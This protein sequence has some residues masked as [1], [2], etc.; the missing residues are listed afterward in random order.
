M[1]SRRLWILLVLL[2]FLLALER[3][4]E[5]YVIM[6]IGDP[7]QLEQALDTLHTDL[8][9]LIK[10]VE[11]RA[12]ESLDDT[13]LVGF[14][15]GFE[16]LRN[17]LPLIDHQMIKEGTTRNLAQSLC[18][19]TMTR[20]LTSTLRI[21]AGEASGRVRA[22]ENLAERMSMTGEPLE[23]L[24]PHLAE[25]QRSGEISSENADL[26][27]RAL[28]PVTRRGFDPEA[29]DAGEQLLARF[30][31][32]F[33]PKDL[34]RLAKQVVDR[35]DPDGTLPDEELQTDRRFFRMRPTKD[36]SYAGE[37]RLTSDCGA[38]LQSLLHPL[39]KPRVNT[40]TTAEGKLIEE[41]DPRSHGQRMHDALHDVCERLLR[42]DN[43]VPDS[44]GTPAT[45]I[46]NID[47][48]DLLAKTGYAITSDG[49]LIKT[50]TALAAA[51]QADI[52]WV[53]AERTGQILHLGRTRRIASRAQTI[54]LYARDLGCSFPGCD[55][56]PD[57][58][59][60]HHILAW[61]E[62]GKTD[63][64]NLTLLCSYHHHNFLAKGWNAGWVNTGCPVAATLVDRPQAHPVDQ[65]ADPRGNCRRRTPT[66]LTPDLGRRQRGPQ[67]ATTR[68]ALDAGLARRPARGSAGG[69][70]T[71]APAAGWRPRRP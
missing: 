41:P 46:I 34:R 23:S 57:W 51:D 6:D 66:T 21:S 36:G 33:G 64:D 71:P 13:G 5:Y 61:S 40:T 31:T 3:L 55:T 20:V 39:A 17:R 8:D 65:R 49:T 7:D 47:L 42:S 15:Q 63:L 38:K 25:K 35:I 10:L 53:F 4:F 43:A 56:P 1:R 24:R 37:F 32:E 14:L 22:A 70:G 59:E 19:G 9:H 11:D 69:R 50:D 54:A 16:R 62:G 44:G 60:R 45:V 27:V 30:A 28:A 52:Y 68:S 18:Q 29:I 67:P 12:L 2:T 48:E 26:V 58:C